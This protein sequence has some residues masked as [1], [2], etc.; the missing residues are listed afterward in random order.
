MCTIILVFVLHDQLY[1]ILQYLSLA[2]AYRMS[3]PYGLRPPSHRFE[4]S[5]LQSVNNFQ[6][7]FPHPPT[8]AVEKWHQNDNDDDD[9][10]YDDDIDYSQNYSD[11]NAGALSIDA[12]S[13]EISSGLT[14]QVQLGQQELQKSLHRSNG[15]Q[16][17]Q[18]R[19]KDRSWSDSL[20]WHD[21][22]IIT[23]QQSRETTEALR[24][25][26]GLLTKEVSH[27]RA[28][29]EQLRASLSDIGAIADA[30]ALARAATTPEK[31]C[32]PV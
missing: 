13:T 20:L 14:S 15:K 22:T 24:W 9:D 29:N 6:L 7:Q 2:F 18:K 8:S 11:E 4:L 16:G 3:R 31:S 21:A 1:I 5:S 10:G 28:E 30:A 12:D 19:K 26:I 32:G 17:P 25:E 23:A 27:L